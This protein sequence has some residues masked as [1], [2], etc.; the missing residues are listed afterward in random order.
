MRSTTDTRLGTHAAAFGSL[1]AGLIHFAVT[2]AHW[3][4]WPPLGAAFGALA[5]FQTLW[6]LAA[7]LAP[8]SRWLL[9]ALPVN[10]AAIGG[11][12]VSRVWGMPF[13]PAT[14]VPEGVAI[15]DIVA[16]LLAVFVAVTV[17]WAWIPRTQY[18]AVR[19]GWYRGSLAAVAAVVAVLVGPAVLTGAAGHEH[20]EGEEHGG[21]GSHDDGH[22]DTEP[23]EDAT[24]HDE[25]TIDPSPTPSQ[26][27]DPSSAP[28]TQDGAGDD[29]D[30]VPHSH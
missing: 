23:H 30:E 29:H 17:A 26:P 20:A 10:L 7:F 8:T 19:L 4:E 5:V 27:A 28:T 3:T 25:V 2:P 11:W 18:A 6:A 22:D 14:G 24:P 21:A 15:A 13:G 9:L 1:G 12:A 16:T